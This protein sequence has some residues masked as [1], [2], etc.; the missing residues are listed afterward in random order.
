MWKYQFLILG[1]VVSE[2][3]SSQLRESSLHRPPH[4][5][6]SL[7]EP[8]AGG[9]TVAKGGGGSPLFSCAELHQLSSLTFGT[10]LG[11]PCLG[12]LFFLRAYE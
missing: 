10:L 9:L 1:C 5:E 2:S 4:S 7:Q 11:T 6:S 12:F 3:L 8:E